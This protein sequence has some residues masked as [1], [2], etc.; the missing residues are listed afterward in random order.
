MAKA[1]ENMPRRPDNLRGTYTCYLAKRAGRVV[2][3]FITC[4]FCPWQ[5]DRYEYLREA[6]VA[7]RK[8]H[9]KDHFDA[10]T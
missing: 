5:S 6:K 1:Q 10:P 3:W 4:K 2:G 8:H 7:F 9:G